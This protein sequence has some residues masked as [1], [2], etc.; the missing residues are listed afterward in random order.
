MN[1]QTTLP[2]HPADGIVPPLPGAT[3]MLKSILDCLFADLI[4]AQAVSPA[5]IQV[6]MTR[7]QVE[8]QFGTPVIHSSETFGVG[9]TTFEHCL[10]D[11]GASVHFYNGRVSEAAVP[12]L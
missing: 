12:R 6:G 3:V 7:V 11:G 4:A 10:Y 2:E 8:D 1:Q 9:D 5:M